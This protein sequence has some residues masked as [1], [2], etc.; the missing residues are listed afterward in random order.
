MA[1]LLTLLIIPA[2]ASADDRVDLWVLVINDGQPWSAAIAGRLTAEGVRHTSVN[3]YAADRQRITREFLQNGDSWAKFQAV[4]VPSDPI[5][6]LSAEEITELRT[7]E[8]RF[9]IREVAAYSWPGSELGFDGFEYIGSLDGITAQLTDT[10]KAQ[11]FGYLQGKVAFED[12]DPAVSETYG[13]LTRTLPGFQPFLT[14][15]KGDANGVLAGTYQHDGREQLLFAFAYNGSQHQFQLLAHGII[16]WVT[17]GVHLGFSR[18]YYSVQVDGRDAEYPRWSSADNCTP[19]PGSVDC[20]N[21]PALPPIKASAEDQFYSRSWVDRNRIRLDEGTAGADRHRITVFYN[22]GTKQEMADEYNWIYTSRANGGSGICE[23]NPATTT[24][25][26]PIDVTTGYDE[27]IVPRERA[28][29][30]RRV[31]GNDPR[32]HNLDG[33]ALAEGRIGYG[34]LEAVIRQYREEFVP[35]LVSL[36][37]PEIDR[38]RRHQAD[39]AAAEDQLVAYVQGGRLVVPKQDIPFAIT[40]PEGSR[41]VGAGPVGQPFGEQYAGERSLRA[42]SQAPLTVS[43][44]Q[45]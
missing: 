13:Y 9:G 43:L 40:V 6:G 26:D 18:N 3:P 5:P 44:P 4:I 31:L 37:Q 30:L 2:T 22:V 36:D 39:S 10:A 20:P 34:P 33:S 24:C 27:Y 19:G 1:G 21:L 29:Q 38:V 28:A 45:P 35:D 7:F 42:I 17:K 16:S 25:I 32:A 11:G 12:N 41:Y 8:R 23:D 14:G 15:I